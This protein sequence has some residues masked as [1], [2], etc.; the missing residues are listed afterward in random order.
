[1]NIK[2]PV[3]FVLSFIVGTSSSGYLELSL[4]CQTGYK[5]VVVHSIRPLEVSACPYQLPIGKTTHGRRYVVSHIWGQGNFGGKEQTWGICPFP[6]RL[7]VCMD[8][9]LRG[10]SDKVGHIL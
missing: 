4:E 2:D 7:R 9:S 8:T 3:L 10:R 1:M 5:T 6:P